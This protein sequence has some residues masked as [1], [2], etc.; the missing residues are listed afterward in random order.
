MDARAVT[1]AYGPWGKPSIVTHPD[2]RFNMSH[3]GSVSAF[4]FATGREVGI[5]IEQRRRVPDKEKIARSVFSPN[6]VSELMSISDSERD[7]AFLRCWTRKEAYIKAIGQ[8]LH[9]RLQSFY[10]KSDF[11]SSVLYATDEDEKPTDRWI[12]Q[13]L[14]LAPEYIAA[15]AYHAKPTSTPL[16]VTIVNGLLFDE[17]ATS[18]TYGRLF[19][20]GRTREL[21]EL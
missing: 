13:D 1:F 12:V 21:W 19:G 15:L 9:K 4:A 10:F 20:L 14:H 6:E 11:Q 16:P 2:L 8:G 17:C 3:A 5:D 18:S 7:D